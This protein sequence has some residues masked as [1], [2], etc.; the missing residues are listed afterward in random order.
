MNSDHLQNMTPENI[1]QYIFTKQPMERCSYQI[2]AEQDDADLTLIFE[3]LVTI[4]MEGIDIFSGGLDNVNLNDFT[5]NHIVGLNPWF[6]SIGFKIKAQI[7]ERDQD[8]DRYCKIVLRLRNRPIFDI[9]NIDKSYHFFINGSA[10]DKN[11]IENKLNNLYATFSCLDK[12]YKINFDFVLPKTNFT[13]V[14]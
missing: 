1:A 8:Y 7:I 3:I 5:M 13:K 2:L 14:L 12:I 10:L 9:K 4:M 6:K 11:K